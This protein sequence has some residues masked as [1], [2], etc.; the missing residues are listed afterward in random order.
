M[1]NIFET[2]K[3]YQA[4][5]Y[6][7][8]DVNF[9]S[10]SG[11]YLIDQDGKKYVDFGSGIAVNALGI[12]DKGWA[13]EIYKQAK[14]L[15]HTSNLFYNEPSA[16]LCKLLCQKSGM[17]KVFLCNSGAEANECAIKAA[18][19]YSFDKYG[20]DRYEIITLNGSFHG[21]TMATLSATGQDS[22]HT[23]FNPFL[24]GFKYV[25]ANDFD[26]L[27]NTVSDKTC[28]VMIELIQG[29]GGVNVLDLQ[30]VKQVKA[31]CDSKDILL[32]I[33]EVQTGNGRT[34][35]MYAYMGYDITP[36]IVTTAK[37]LGGGLP[38]G[39]CMFNFKTQNVLGPGDHGSTFGGNPICSS[40]AIYVLNHINDALLKNINEKSTYI[41][42][43]LNAFENVKEVSGKGLMIGI[44]VNCGNNKEI[45]KK[46]KEKGL[47]VLTAKD[48]IRLLPALTI[49]YKTIDEGLKILKEV[50][51]NEASVK[52]V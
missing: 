5:T 27:K 31:L 16:E 8:T 39:A 51:E 11:S 22:F 52:T 34:G 50:I 3:K 32:I 33:D 41:F 24:D 37:G 49:D 47:I 26:S 23:K 40:G 18:R 44:S 20:A 13:K 4:N 43:K 30:Y 42:E 1:E 6:S 7:K 28:A 25:N 35:Q 46:C 19:K 10:G 2:D 48:K 45:M 14:K 21:R 12:S 29:E 9:V 15:N 38:I 36:D 17:S